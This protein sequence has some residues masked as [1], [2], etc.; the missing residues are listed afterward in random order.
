MCELS[1]SRNANVR[2]ANM[3]EYLVSR[4]SRPGHWSGVRLL[5]LPFPEIIELDRH[6]IRHDRCLLTP[7]SRHSLVE[8]RREDD[9]SDMDHC[10]YDWR[11]WPAHE[12][13]YQRQL[14]GDLGCHSSVS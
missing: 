7:R 13:R 8:L 3:G 12:A 4:T 1:L 9:Y 2:P 10:W 5:Q 14:E 6:F 11:S